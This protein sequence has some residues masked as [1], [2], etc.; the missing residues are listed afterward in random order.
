MCRVHACDHTNPLLTPFL[1]A[2]AGGQ[3]GRAYCQALDPS[4]VQLHA[5][6]AGES[7]TKVAQCT[8]ARRTK[9]ASGQIVDLLQRAREP[10][11]LFVEPPRILV[12]TLIFGR[13]TRGSGSMPTTY[14][15]C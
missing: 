13:A 8:K 4:S 12:V 3:V 14:C 11:Q 15:C 5:H 2:R 6:P 9:D 10:R 1:A 7:R